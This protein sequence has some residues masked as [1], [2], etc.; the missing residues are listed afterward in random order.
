MTPHIHHHKHGG[1]VDT[2]LH[3]REHILKYFHGK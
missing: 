1:H 3:H 2:H